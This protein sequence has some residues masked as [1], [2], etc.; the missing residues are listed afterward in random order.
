MR[1]FNTAN[2]NSAF[3]VIVHVEQENSHDFFASAGQVGLLTLRARPC[4]ITFAC[5]YP[6]TPFQLTNPV[7]LIT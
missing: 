7:L 1:C 6:F 5:L 4:V 3:F 2:V